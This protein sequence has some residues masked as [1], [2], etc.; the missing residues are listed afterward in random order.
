MSDIKAGDLVMVVKPSP[1][2]CNHDVGSVYVVTHKE[3]SK[4]AYCD[5]C[6]FRIEDGI[7]LVCDRKNHGTEIDR[8]I[9][10]A[11]PALPESITTNQDIPEHA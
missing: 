6:D 10:I 1:C 7:V 9:K 4:W 11:P 8:V 3:T 5:F 2:G